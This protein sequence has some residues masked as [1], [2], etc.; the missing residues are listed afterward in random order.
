MEVVYSARNKSSA[1]GRKDFD[2]TY[3]P[4]PSDL[5]RVVFY[6]SYVVLSALTDWAYTGF[7]LIWAGFSRSMGIDY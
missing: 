6:G 2:K 3:T 5:S 7:F 4:I 1:W